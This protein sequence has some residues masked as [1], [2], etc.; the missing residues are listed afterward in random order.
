MFK[1][2]N[3]KDS[4]V[5]SSLFLVFYS[6]IIFILKQNLFKTSYVIFKKLQ[7]NYLI[8]AFLLGRATILD[9]L[10]PFAI[11]FFAVMYHFKREKLF[12]ITV[13]I[14]LG[15]NMST[16]DQ[17]VAIFFGII[18]FFFLQQFL[19]KKNKTEL[20]YA[21]LLVFIS[22]VIPQ[23]TS[24]IYN[25]VSEFFPWMMT[26]IEAMLGFVLTLI[27]VQALPIVMYK[28]DDVKLSQEEIIALAIVLAST[29]TGT[30]GWTIYDLSVENIFSRYL[31]LIFAFA[32]GGPIGAS[33]GV[34]TGL[35]L[36]LA[37]PNAIYQISLL[38]FSGLL[39]GLLKQAN[40][41]G[42]GLG[43]L[44]GTTILSMYLGNQYDIIK[45]FSESS[46]AILLFILT[47]KF[48]LKE[49]AKY[50]PGTNE[51]HDHYND[52][53]KKI[54]NITS[55]K[56][57]QFA[58]MF[59]QLASSFKEI[60]KPSFLDQNQQLEHFMSKISDVHCSTCWKRN[61]C[62]NTEFYRTYNLMTELMIVIE[63]KS[64][65]TKKDIPQDWITHCV[66]HTQVTFELVDIYQNY[67]D[68]LYWKS[69]LEE[70][71]LLVSHQLYGV[72][73]VMKDL[74]VEIQK[75]GKEL[76]VQEDLIRHALENLGL[77]VRQVNIYSLEEG[78]VDIE[79][80][81]PTCNNTDECTKVIAPL[82]SEVLDENI[83]VKN[84][85]CDLNRDGL[86]KLCLQSAKTYELETGYAIAA[87]GGKWLSG[88]SFS[89]IE[90]SNGKY[91]VA[92]SDG[93][94]NGEKAQRE[95][96]A[97]LELLKQLLHSGIDETISIKTIN[98]ILLLR[99]QEEIFSTIDL[100]IIDLF[101]GKTKF[102]KVGSTPS[103]IKRGNEVIAIEAS[104]LP[105]GIIQDIEIDSIESDLI[106]G[107]LLVMMTDGVFD[108][109]KHTN[110]KELWIKRLIQEIQTDNPQEFADLLL[111]RVIRSGQGE[112]IDD[113]T[114][115]V[116]KIEKYVPEWSTIKIPGMVRI[117]RERAN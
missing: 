101:N 50:I 86:C 104:N 16:N 70:S 26:V 108:S 51:Y 1:K 75:E 68:Y 57:D 12:F 29:M 80:I 98:S 83:V 22:I 5:I 7:L 94:G 14:L 3:G 113:M 81:Q 117:E 66:K 10:S 58:N 102:L 111:E 60:A 78:C 90:I 93:M 114:V 37:N 67:G 74:S 92:L 103:F 59:D 40:K 46:I 47:P 87:K 112:I 110:N 85:T 31:I 41:F 91:A 55:K 11:P 109:P 24:H 42:V 28:R 72:S 49:V 62:W 63:S 107:D 96:K 106:P 69:Q 105:I 54:K 116:S 2:P 77:S 17:A 39:A 100:A 13:A 99:S 82:I 97:T 44:L 18:L 15:A 43:L 73:K 34:I 53:V 9:D 21:P 6:R 61:R 88:D 35:I 19:D 48:L 30:L 56:I 64:E 89:M 38:A 115:I 32:G 25:D 23:F 33:I 79:I 8:M 20:S 84:K 45:S 52:Y 65:M 71:R 76:G 36:S 27:F 95:S 4:L